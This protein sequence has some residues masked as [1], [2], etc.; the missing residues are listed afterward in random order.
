MSLNSSGQKAKHEMCAHLIFW[1]KLSDLIRG[2]F[3]RSSFAFSAVSCFTSHL[4]INFFTFLS[5]CLFSCV[6]IVINE[7]LSFNLRMKS[8]ASMKYFALLSRTTYDYP[9]NIFIP[10]DL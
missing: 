2:F 7:M 3:F 4:L 10:L 9:R 1:V 5:L 8:P 6:L